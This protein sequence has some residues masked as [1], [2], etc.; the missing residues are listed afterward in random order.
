MS[1]Y[2]FDHDYEAQQMKY[3]E[4][5]LKTDRKMWKLVL[6]HFV[7]L[8]IYS[9]FFFTPFSDDIDRIAPRSDRSKTFNYLPA[10]VLSIFTY[11]IVL[12]VWHYQ[13]ARRVEEAIEVRRI[14]YEFGTK[15]FWCWFILGSF[16]LVGP[17]VYL[18]K[19]C[20]AMNMLCEDYNEKDLQNKK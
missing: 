16:I 13:M 12:D 9:I 18:H 10:F 8:G 1:N 20:K 17:F 11:S 15:D 19:L 4:P 6:L 5:M 14:D 2:K 7:T 3:E